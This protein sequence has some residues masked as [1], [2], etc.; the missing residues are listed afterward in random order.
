MQGYEA[1]VVPARAGS[2]ADEDW[3]EP[4]VQ[5][6]PDG[7]TAIEYVYSTPASTSGATSASFPDLKFRWQMVYILPLENTEVVADVLASARA[8]ELSRIAVL[9]GLPEDTL[10]ALDNR[11]T[12]FLKPPSLV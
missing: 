6:W 8:M 10:S 12:V 9:G 2:I 5:L 1:L 4:L 3:L 7:R 11:F